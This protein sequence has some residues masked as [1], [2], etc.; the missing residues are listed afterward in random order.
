MTQKIKHKAIKCNMQKC[1]KDA[2]YWFE[3]EGMPLDTFYLCDDHFTQ[4]TN[5]DHEVIIFDTTKGT[6]D[7][8]ETGAYSCN[9]NCTTCN[10]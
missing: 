8:V 4:V 1:K 7:T 9:E 5:D 2:S 3:Q 6:V 10:Q